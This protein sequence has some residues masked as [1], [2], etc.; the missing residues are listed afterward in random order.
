MNLY[1]GVAREDTTPKIGAHIYGYRPDVCSE[2]VHD[3]LAAVV[4]AF[5]YENVMSIM[6]SVPICLMANRI[7]NDIRKSISEEHN[8]NIDNV[9]I[10]CTH[11][12][13]GPALHEQSGWGDLDEEYYKSIFKPAVLKAT[14]NALNSLEP[15]KVGIAT[16]DSFVGVNRR[17]ITL[18]GN[19][20][21]GQKPWGPF[22]PKM[23]VISF[24]N[25]KNEVIGNIIHYGA[26]QT[27]AGNRP[28]I[29]R[30]WSGVMTDAVEAES[31]GITAFFNGPEGDV[32]PRLSNGR[33]V[34]DMS[35]V[36]EL[37]KVAANDALKIYRSITSYDEV[38]F[39]V[40]AS[41]ICI[42]LL[43]RIPYSEAIEECEKPMPDD[44]VNVV[45]LEHEYHRGVKESYEKGYEDKEYREINQVVIKIG[46]VVFVSF[47]Y[48]LF[49]EIGMRIDKEF[50]EYEVLSLSNANGSEGY[51]PTK[52][53]LC[54][55]GYEV[56]MFKYTE[57]QQYVDN[58]DC[59]LA[60]GSVKNVKKLLG[61][62]D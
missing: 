53:Q 28:I 31:G 15:V 21:F 36:E 61:Q 26:H 8:I 24:K 2:S 22:E 55:G 57:I 50:P 4:F 58:A 30:D 5:K 18:D 1:L 41:N 51:F 29:S 42:P 19:I 62:N 59:Y 13:S 37:G 32:G 27:A 11:T 38:D 54:I 14:D 17:Q 7:S 3:N 12:H 40:E 35:H 6:I 43:P 34:G 46:K 52:D 25:Y 23:T 20:I 16:G 45:K 60:M 10:A 49:S 48:E 33:T 44:C 9:V 56:D 39:A 47:P